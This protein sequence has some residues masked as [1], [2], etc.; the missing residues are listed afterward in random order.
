M[1]LV[2]SFLSDRDVRG[3]PVCHIRSIVLFCD[4]P[5]FLCLSGPFVQQQRYP[6][7]CC[8]MGEGLDMPVVGN[9][10]DFPVLLGWGITSRNCQRGHFVVVVAA[11]LLCLP[12]VH[13]CSFSYTTGF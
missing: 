3:G 5:L 1:G 12:V 13:Y 10:L 2:D 6:S 11:V 9:F 8:F 7:R 4:T